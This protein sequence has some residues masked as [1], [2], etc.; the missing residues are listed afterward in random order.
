MIPEVL[1]ATY[2][3]DKVKPG[4]VALVLVVILCLATVLLWRSMNTQLRRIQMPPKPPKPPLPQASDR[5]DPSMPSESGRSMLSDESP[6]AHRVTPDDPT[7]SSAD[8]E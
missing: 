7:R 4:L 2:D 6:G 1:L 3:P 5:S 8:D